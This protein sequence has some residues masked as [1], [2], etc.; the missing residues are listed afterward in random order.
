MALLLEGS[1]S[2]KYVLVAIDDLISRP[3]VAPSLCMLRMLPEGPRLYRSERSKGA[4]RGLRA[5]D[6]VG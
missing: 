5:S 2:L 1:L 4:T 6:P 3:T